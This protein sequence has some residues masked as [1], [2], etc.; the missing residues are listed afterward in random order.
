MKNRLWCWNT[1]SH[2]VDEKMLNDVR[3][4][5]LLS[6]DLHYIFENEH[7]FLMCPMVRNAKIRQSSMPIII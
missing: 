3:N 7:A 4:G 6:A 2:I 1:N 5:V